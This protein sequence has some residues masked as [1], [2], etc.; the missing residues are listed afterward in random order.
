[1]TSSKPIA[2]D[3]FAGCG[4]LTRGLRQ[5]GF[6]VAAAVEV[7]PVACKTYRHNNRKTDLVEKDIRDVTGEQILATV[8]GGRVDLLAGCA[9]CQ[10]F[11]SLTAKYARQ[12]PRNML[13]LEMLRLIRE[14][15][16]EALMMENVPGLASRG[17]DVF[18]D[19]LDGIREIGYLPAHEVI[20]MADYGVPQSRRRLVLL[21]GR[22][23]V[24][25]L[26]VKTHAKKPNPTSDLPE[27]RTLRDAIAG[28]GAPAKLSE[29]LNQDGPQ[30][31]NWHVVRD[32]QP[33]TRTR[34][35]AAR[36]G[37]TWLGIDEKIRPRCH[38]DGYNGFTNTYG[39]MAWDSASVTITAGCTTPCKG[40]FGHPDRRRTTISVREAATLQTFPE[41]YRFRTDY[42]D[43]VCEM[44]GN[45]VPPLFARRAGHSIRKTLEAHY[46]ALA[47][48]GAEQGNDVRKAEAI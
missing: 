48:K 28:N 24:I 31:L 30:A 33:Q 29:A 3:L 4:G 16:P 36:P 32:L 15:K 42:M 22:G 23:F 21:A 17:Q 7:D 1:M 12:D 37:K 6:H 47:G 41:N 11:C 13:V 5:A 8:P 14:I 26:P 44:I 18:D 38:R 35:K 45:A 40:R 20:Q 46:G 39:R 10:G 19:F 27:W 43:L 9:P 2:I 34:L 25:P